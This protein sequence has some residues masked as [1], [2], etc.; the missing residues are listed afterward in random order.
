MTTVALPNIAPVSFASSRDGLS[1][2]LR[3][4]SVSQWLV[5]L[6]PV[7]LFAVRRQ[8]EAEAVDVVDG[9]AVAQILFTGL[10]A[11]WLFF[12]CFK[13]GKAVRYLLF[14]TPLGFL[15]AYA[16]LAIA[17][18]AWTD[19]IELT[20]FRS[21]QLFAFLLLICDAI[22]SCRDIRD[23]IRLQLVYALITGIFWELVDIHMGLSALHSS[24]VPGLAIGAVFLGWLSG[25]KSW[26]FVYA[27]LLLIFIF[28]SS[29]GA[30]LGLL[31]GIASATLLTRGRYAALG[32]LVIGALVVA[33]LAVPDDLGAIVFYGKTN[34]NIQTA[35][36]RLPV[37]QELIEDAV[38]KRPWL[39]WGF[40]VG[41]VHARLYGKGFHLMH[42]HSSVMS[43]LMNLGGVGLALL[44]CFWAG[45]L[46]VALKLKDRRLRPLMFGACLAVILNSL[47]MESVT[48]P[49]S[50]GWIGH[51]L[52]FTTVIAVGIDEKG[53]T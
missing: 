53:R 42:M 35:S 16:L 39:G 22:A 50:L 10:C 52:L 21:L 25:N 36:G 44:L 7:F 30:F 15:F 45:V 2:F 1:A 41:E 9:S 32:W 4:L 23:I 24:M 29:A 8:R 11:F 14:S 48:A 26:R 34:Q 20:A 17:S 12:R 3:R 31:L 6:F 13:A 5:L 38:S 40:A 49:L 47:A 28:G 19:K 18:L 43:A 37:W 33:L 51:A 27:L 46:R